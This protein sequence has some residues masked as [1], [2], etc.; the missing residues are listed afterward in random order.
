MKKYYCNAAERKLSAM[1][2]KVWEGGMEN[3]ENVKNAKEGL[4]SLMLIAN[5]EKVSTGELNR[6]ISNNDWK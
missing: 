4:S 5:P 2:C 3:I 1:V 6:F